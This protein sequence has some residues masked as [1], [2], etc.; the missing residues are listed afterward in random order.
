MYSHPDQCNCVDTTHALSI[1]LADFTPEETTF[2]ESA[3][4]K[5]LKKIYT[6][7]YSGEFPEEF[8][9]ITVGKLNEAVSSEFGKQIP[10][11]ANQLKYQNSVFAAFKSAHQTQTLENLLA[12]SK[13]AT[14]TDFAAEV[15]S[16]VK[17][18]NINHLRAEWNT[19]KKAARSAKR[20]AKAIENADIFPNIEYTPSTALDPRDVHKPYY[21]MIAPIDDPVWNG[22]LPPS[23]WGCQC[24]WKT[25]DKN[26]TQKP[27][28]MPPPEPG[29]DNNPGKNGALI[30][31]SHPYFKAKGADEIMKSNIA[32][33]YGIDTKDI[34]EFYRDPKTNG[35][36]FSVEKL[37]KT[38]RAA[39]KRIAK[40]YANKGSVVELY[41]SDS[42]D[43]IVNGTW[44][45]FK[46]P[47]AM[48]ENAFSKRLGKANS[49][50]KDR[51]LKGDATF[52]L[53]EKYDANIIRTAF[54]KKVN[55]AD[56]ENHLNFVHFTMKGKYLG[57]AT[58]DDII[59]GKL[60]I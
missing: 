15:Q 3:V 42:L 30:S 8:W 17:D 34:T 44:N 4:E 50:L 24:G 48:T 6:G 54:R 58:I 45:E 40:A 5:A 39:N 55:R 26:V 7:Q 23:D 21:G 28:T 46:T 59:K 18:Y 1:H 31:P 11:L 33:M 10:E 53:P 32:A 36:Y 27:H 41:G 60:P 19:A 52:E 37:A 35:C 29:L 57:S 16:T 47:D 25:T 20:W 43:S 51:K 38:E 22:I 49:Q 12:A 56:Y 2:I 14:F 13:A 9:N